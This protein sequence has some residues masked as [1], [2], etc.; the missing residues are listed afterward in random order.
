MENSQTGSSTEQKNGTAEGA[1]QIDSSSGATAGET[2]PAEAQ[3]VG[4]T[5]E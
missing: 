5:D 4:L 1:M 3:K 2:K